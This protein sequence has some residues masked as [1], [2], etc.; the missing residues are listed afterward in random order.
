MRY[1]LEAPMAMLCCLSDGLHKECFGNLRPERLCT[2]L[3]LDGLQG[4]GN[5]SSDSLEAAEDYLDIDVLMDDIPAE[6]PAADWYTL[7]P[8]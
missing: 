2:E 5:I 3:A 1:C 7:Q 8:I 6:P 4:S